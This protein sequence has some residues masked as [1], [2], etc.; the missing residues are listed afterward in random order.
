LSSW[1]QDLRYAARTLARSP[2]FAAVA[3]ATLALGI[4]ANTAIFSVVHAVLFR[5][6]G[7]PD[8]DRLVTLEERDRDGSGD[9][10]GFPTYQDWRTRSKS[11]QE[12]AVAS[13]WTPTLGAQG[14]SEAEKL[15]GLH[16]SDGFFRML[17]VRPMLGR[18][19]LAEEDRPSANRVALLGYGLWKR[20]FGGDPSLPGRT[21]R[22]GDRDFLVA[23]VLPPNFESVFSPFPGRPTEIWAPLGYDQTLPYACR[24][25][26]HLRAFG[27]LRAGVSLESARSELAS[28]QASIVSEHPADYPSAGV[29]V[30]PFSKQLTGQSRAALLTLLGAVGLVLLIASANVGSLMLARATGRQREVAIRCA[31]G[32]DRG[33]VARLFLTEALLVAALGGALGLAVAGATMGSLVAVAPAGLPRLSETRLDPIV[34][35]FAAALSIASGLVFGLAPALRFARTDPEAYLRQGSRASASRGARRFSGLLVAFDS[36]MVFVLLFGAG[37]LVRTSSRL[38]SV[39]PG[40]TPAGLLQLEV[41]VS[42]AE[43]RGDGS[44]AALASFYERALARIQVL[45]GVLSAGATSQVPLGGNFDGYGVHIEGRAEPNPELAP[46]ADRYSVTPDYLKTMRIPIL[47][48]RGI[49]EADRRDA[50]LVVLI[51]ETLAKN[52]F[53][54]SDPIGQR[55]RIGGPDPPWRTIVGV[56]GDV[57]HTALDAP[58][59]NQ[60]YLPHAQFTDSDMVVVVRTAG[61]PIDVAP[62]A[63]ALIHSVDPNQAVMH[64]ETVEQIVRTSAASRLFA[65]SLSTAFAGLAVLLAAVGVFGVVSGFVARRSREIGIR[66]ALGARRSQILRRVVGEAMALAAGGV[67]LAVPVALALGRAL[68]SQLYAVAPGDGLL[69][70]SVAALA[71]L[72]ALVAS[73]LPARQAT[74]ISPISALRAE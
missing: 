45:P 1:I 64:V 15:E 26:R 11:F 47:R 61:N 42:G 31:L 72:V 56:V 20:R 6:L 41:S 53:A 49:T 57:L 69:L 54:G 52:E 63:R 40:F 38:L 28:V 30:E 35:A 51:N 74:R 24:T 46:T 66:M 9:N 27:R 71:V 44:A 48:G 55:V 36:A 19:F 25:C 59:T 29:L 12:V 73:F 65:A 21:I 18:D 58:R 17:G 34:L 68:K 8:P 62:A 50:P 43:Y 3:I 32:A 13:Y 70:S 60:I 39:N 10:T 4:G 22:M 16:V 7:F 14:S 67:A 5:P 37:L 2:G 23:G 33:R